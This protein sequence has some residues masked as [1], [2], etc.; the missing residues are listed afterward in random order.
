[1]RPPGSTAVMPAC[2]GAAAASTRSSSPCAAS[3]HSDAFS[4]GF[5]STPLPHTSASAAFHAHTATGKL[6]AEI[7]PHRPYGC[8]VSRIACCGRSEAMVSPCS[9]RDRPTAKSQISIISCTSPSPSCRILPVSSDTSRPS[10]GLCSRST[11][12]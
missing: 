1:M 3:A 8:Q 4:D 11:S 5:H 7:T 6:K 10:A 12:P 9:W 2:C